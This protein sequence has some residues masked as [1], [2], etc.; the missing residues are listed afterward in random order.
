MVDEVV[1]EP[2]TARPDSSEY[3][4]DGRVP[5]ETATEIVPSDSP[6]AASPVSVRKRRTRTLPQTP[7]RR[8]VTFTVPDGAP[9]DTDQG[10]DQPSPD[11]VP[12]SPMTDGPEAKLALLEGLMFNPG[13]VG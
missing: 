12:D 2:D 4:G 11:R 5:G 13:E 8:H 9:G 3:Q 10:P 1:A 6:T 7:Q